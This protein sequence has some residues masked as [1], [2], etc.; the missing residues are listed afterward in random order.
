[1]Y[2]CILVVMLPK[3][4]ALLLGTALVSHFGILA[5]LFYMD[6]KRD[7]EYV[8]K[9]FAAMS[10]RLQCFETP[11]VWYKWP[12][13]FPCSLQSLRR[14]TSPK[15]LTLPDTA[16]MASVWQEMGEAIHNSVQLGHT[17]PVNLNLKSREGLPK[18]SR[19]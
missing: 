16:L 10:S 3:L 18:V 2:V 15:H 13:R 12:R 4:K 6:E 11:L 14:C 7:D 17:H 9:A 5:S 8:C 19:R 1:V